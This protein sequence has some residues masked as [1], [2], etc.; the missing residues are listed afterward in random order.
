MVGGNNGRGC[1]SCYGE[2]IV[3][4]AGQL[5]SDALSICGNVSAGDRIYLLSLR[6]NRSIV[7]SGFPFH[8]SRQAAS[9]TG[10]LVT[11]MRFPTSCGCHPVVCCSRRI[12]SDVLPMAAFQFGHPIQFLV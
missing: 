11:N 6:D 9:H 3:I 8:E 2:G 4:Q 12:M 10:K 5:S 1:H 7:R